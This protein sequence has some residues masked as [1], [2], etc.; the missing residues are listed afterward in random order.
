MPRRRDK[1]LWVSYVGAFEKLERAM[2]YEFFSKATSEGRSFTVI[3]A[4]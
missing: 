4:S 2:K 1:E 3:S